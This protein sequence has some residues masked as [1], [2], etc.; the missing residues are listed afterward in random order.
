MP[1]ALRGPSLFG[2]PLMMMKPLHAQQFLTV[3]RHL[4]VISGSASPSHAYVMRLLR[5]LRNMTYI[6]RYKTLKVYSKA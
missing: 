3:L 5:G 1:P 2:W 4:A 6:N